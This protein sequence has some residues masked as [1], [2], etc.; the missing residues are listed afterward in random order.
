MPATATK[1]APSLR[2]VNLVKTYGDGA[3]RR[4][5]L[6]NV[7]IDLHP[8]EL[9][10]LMGPSGSGKSTLLAVLSGLLEP[11]S[12]QVLAEDD[13]RLREVWHLTPK[14]REEYRRRHTGFVFQGYNLF[15]ALTARQQLEIVL[16]WGGSLGSGEARHR[17]DEMLDKLGLE[18]NKHKKPAQLSG[19]EK[20]RVAIARALVKNP[21][22]V[23][24][25][26]P[27]SALDW[28]NGQKV[29]EL[30]RDAAHERRASIL[31]VSHDHRLLPFVDVYYHLEDGHLERRSLDHKH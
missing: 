8:G 23:F 21:N 6:H 2:G 9:V 17:A 5:T 1:T 15:P 14:E 11:D 25:D 24:A 29:I 27:T 7:S 10:L 31:V 18:K 26:E 22:F 16:K 28:E 4:T 12:G 19:G 20:Q 3:T 30:L 13:G